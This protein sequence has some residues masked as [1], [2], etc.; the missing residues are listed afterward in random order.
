[1]QGDYF[2]GYLFAFIAAVIWS[3]YTIMTRL[4]RETPM[5]MVGMYC[6]IGSIIS[7]GLHLIFETWVAPSFTDSFMVILLGLS[8]GIA[9][10]LWTYGIQKG[11]IKMLGVLAYF[12]PVLSMSLL[13]LS[14]KE[15][16]SIA[17]VA[18]C[19]LVVLGVVVGSVNWSK[20][21]KLSFNS[22]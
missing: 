18:A 5:E 4:F 15:P 21:K 8:S 7:L 2:Y 13:V 16:M 14:G 22:A 3:S 20:L 17:L 12:T 9:Y 19:F 10:L 6:G 1:M 11:N